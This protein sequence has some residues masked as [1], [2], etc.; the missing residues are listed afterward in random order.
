MTGK[1][2]DRLDEALC[3]IRSTDAINKLRHV[4]PYVY[5]IEDTTYNRQK[6]SQAPQ[7]S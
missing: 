3:D 2:E 7:A 4:A 5:L 1:L 6:T